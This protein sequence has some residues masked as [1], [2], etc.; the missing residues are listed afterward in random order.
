MAKLC[1][2]QVSR[3]T[4]HHLAAKG[5]SERFHRILKA[6]IMYHANQQ[7]TEALPLFV[8]GIRTAF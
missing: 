4:D 6:G 7:W 3:T 8:F 2:I 5:I 1:R